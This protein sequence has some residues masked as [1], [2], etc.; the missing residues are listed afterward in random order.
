[1]HKTYRLLRKQKYVRDEQEAAARAVAR[2]VSDKAAA[3]KVAAE[4]VAAAEAATVKNTA[5]RDEASSQPDPNLKY[6]ASMT[7]KFPPPV[8]TLRNVP[9]PHLAWP[10]T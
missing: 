7:V 6:S 2:K 9:R 4:Q 1:V 8:E 5:A 3:E 10:L